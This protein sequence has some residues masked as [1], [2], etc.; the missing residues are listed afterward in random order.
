MADHQRIALKFNLPNCT[1]SL[2]KSY[3][4]PCS[5]AP[6]GYLP[7]LDPLLFG[8]Q[9]KDV[10]IMGVLNAQHEAW[11][12]RTTSLAGARTVDEINESVDASSFVLNREEPTRLPARDPPSSPYVSVISVHLSLDTVWSVITAL[13]SNNRPIIISPRSDTPPKSIPCCITNFQKA[14]WEGYHKQ[15]EQAFLMFL[16][17]PTCAVDAGVHSNEF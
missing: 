14:D 15:S 5:P 11:F 9:N 6:V 1:L 17:P 10:L 7:N 3:F 4:Q 13:N 8:L 12:Y 2:V 16:P